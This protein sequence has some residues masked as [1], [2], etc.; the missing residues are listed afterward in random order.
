VRKAIVGNGWPS[1]RELA[2][3]ISV[4]FPVLRVYLEQDRRWEER[5]WFN[6]FDAI[7]LILVHLLASPVTGYRLG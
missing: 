7:A 4:R 3:P 6:L 2:S 1:K 5:Y